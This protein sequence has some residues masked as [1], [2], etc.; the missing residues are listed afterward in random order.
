MFRLFVIAPNMAN[1]VNNINF[2]YPT[3]LLPFVYPPYFGFNPLI[4]IIRIKYVIILNIDSEIVF[5]YS[6]RTIIFICNKNKWVLAIFNGL[7][8]L[9]SDDVNPNKMIRL[10]P[11]K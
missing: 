11:L 1:N 6:T 3:S 7:N 10:F 8:A 2:S 9:C 4:V 5:Q